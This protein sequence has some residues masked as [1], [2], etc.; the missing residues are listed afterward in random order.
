M[1]N[2]YFLSV[3]KSRILTAQIRDAEQ[4][5]LIRQRGVGVRTD[6]L[7]KKIHRQMT[8][9]STLLLTVGIGFILGELTKR[10]RQTTVNHDVAGK[11]STTGTS[12]LRIALNLLSTVHTL[13]MALPTTW[14]VR[15][16]HPSAKPG[17]Q[18]PERQAKPLTAVSSAAKYSE[19]SNR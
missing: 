8:A 5:L 3:S 7:I 6:T 15:I 12:P 2:T 13:Y 9:P 10:K 18:A 19:R 4:Q 11:Q 17:R 14:K 16:F 1:I